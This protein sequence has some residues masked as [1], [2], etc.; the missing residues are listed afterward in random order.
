MADMA[1]AVKRILVAIQNHEPIVIFGDYDVDGSVPQPCWWNSCENR[2][3]GGLLHSGSLHRGIRPQRAAVRTLAQ[4]YR[5]L[6][7]VDCGISAVEEI[8]VANDLGL[9][10]IVA[11]HHQAPSEIPPAVACL[12][13][14]RPDCHYPFK[15]LCAAG[16]AFLLAAALRRALRESGGFATKP[17]PDLRELLDLV[18]LATVADMVPLKGTNRTLVAI[19]L[20]L[21]GHVHDGGLLPCARSPM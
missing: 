13:P 11:D 21:W 12:D 3:P 14:H 16:V 17:E 6:I 4:E 7:A 20:R 5:L 2:R 9:D 18:A 1:K 8:R 15:D 19:G 10:V